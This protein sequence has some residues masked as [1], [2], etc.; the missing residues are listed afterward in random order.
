MTLIPC[1]G[2]YEKKKNFWLVLDP[3]KYLVIKYLPI[4]L[5]LTNYLVILDTCLFRF[6]T[7]KLNVPKLISTTK[8]GINTFI[9][10]YTCYFIQ[11]IQVI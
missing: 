5:I 2:A 6:K 8:H 1:H 10:P 3:I 11:S 7:L 4:F 9:F